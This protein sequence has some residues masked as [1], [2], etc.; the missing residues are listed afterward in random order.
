[1]VN[2]K[3]LFEYLQTELN[4]TEQDLESSRQKWQAAQRKILQD[5][6]GLW[7][8]LDP[9]QTQLEFRQFPEQDLLATL[10]LW[11]EAHQETAGVRWLTWLDARNGRHQEDFKLSPGCRPGLVQAANFSFLHAPELESAPHLFQT[12]SWFDLQHQD[13]RQRQV[14]LLLVPEHQLVLVGVR[15][16]GEVLAV[17]LQDFQVLERWSLREAGS[18]LALNMAVDAEAETLYMTDNHSA[19]LWIVELEDFSHKVFQSGLGALGNLA[20]APVRGKLYLC[21]LRPQ[22]SLV[23]FDTETMQA[24]YSV[25]IKGAS[26]T[27]KKRL[28]QDPFALLEGGKRLA[29]LAW[30][31]REGHEQPAVNVIDGAEVAILRRYALKVE[32]RPVQL[33][34]PA[35]NPFLKAQQLDYLT[36]L[37]EQGL[38]Q[39]SALEQWQVQREEA[40]AQAL[41]KPQKRQLKPVKHNFRIFQPPKPDPELWDRIGEKGEEIELPNAALEAIVDLI[42]WAFYRM[43]LTNLRIHT[44]EIKRIYGIARKIKEEL[45]TQQ[46]VLAKLDHVLGRHQFQTPIDRKDV[47]EVMRRAK[48]SGESFRLE[49]LCPICSGPM[50]ETGCPNCGFM[51]QLPPDQRLPLESYSA[52][53]AT[54][55]FPGQML[56]AHAP[57]KRL[58]TLN[59]WRQP[60]QE[61]D[62]NPAGL[63]SVQAAVALPNQNFLVADAVGNKVLEVSPSGDVLWW[64]KLALKRPVQATWYQGEKELHYLIVDQGNARILEM[65]P[66]GKHL[67]R[68]PT[69]KTPDEDKLK[70]PVD[71][72]FTETDT[73]LI[74][75]L[76]LP[77]VLEVDRRGS[78]VRGFGPEQGVTRPLAARRN[79]DGSTEILDAGS[80]TWLHFD[81]E[82]QEIERF[83]YWPPETPDGE[84]WRAKVAPIWGG[85]LHNGE[86]I[87]LGD[88]YFMF[89]APALGLIRWVAALPDP[90][91]EN[92]LLKVRF[93]TRSNGDLRLQKLKEF[94][95]ALKKVP[96]LNE[97]EEEKIQELARY[98]HAVKIRAGDWLNAPGETPNGICFLLEGELELRAPEAEQPLMQTLGSGEICGSEAAGSLEVLQDYQPGLKAKTEVRLLMLDRGD[99]KRA[100]VVFPRLFT[101]VKQLN[102]DYGRLVKHFK[103]RKMELF[104]GNLRHS[105]AESKIREQALFQTASDDFME[106]LAALVHPHAYLPDQEVFGRG[107]SGGSMFLILEGKVG[108]MRK[109]EQRPSVM[110]A[111]GDLFGEMSLIFDMPRSVTART[112]DYC[113]FF[114]MEYEALKKIWVR[115][116]WFHTR[117]QEMARQRQEENQAYDLEYARRSGTDRSDLPTVQVMPQGLRESGLIFYYASLRHDCVLGINLPGE[118]LWYWGQEPQRQLFQPSRS[119]YLGDSLLVTDSGNDRVLEI[120]LRSREILRHWRGQLN[121]PRSGSLTPE[122]FLLVADQGNQR[123]VVINEEGR[124]LWTHAAPKEILSPTFA[125]ITPN[126]TILFAD[127]GLHQV[128]EI[129]RTGE[130]LWS[131]GEM[132]QAGSADAQLSAPQCVRRLEDGSTLIADTGNRRL[133]WLH[134]EAKNKVIDLSHLDPPLE[135]QHCDLLETGEILVFS[136]EQ[137]RFVRLTR[138]GEVNWQADLSFPA[139]TEGMETHL[140]QTQFIPPEE[141]WIL[142]LERLDELDERMPEAPAETAPP[143]ADLDAALDAALEETEEEEATVTRIMNWH[144][145]SQ[146][147][148][149]RPE[150]PQAAAAAAPEQLSEL[151][152][153]LTSMEEKTIG[154]DHKPV[155]WSADKKSEPESESEEAEDLSVDGEEL[156]ALFAELEVTGTRK[157]VEADLRSSEAEQASEEPES[158][159]DQ[160]FLSELDAALDFMDGPSQ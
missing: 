65:E 109:G 44:D 100:V 95:A 20:C 110:L 66:G 46:V 47:F 124:E 156:D 14:D 22:L 37:Q 104:Q 88:D 75:D 71:V 105:L 34:E 155:Q 12:R 85:R 42:N 90:A 9:D 123:L 61:V 78:V 32:N 38:V 149:Q 152:D 86:W 98:V 28:P 112:L 31:V 63:K 72:Q 126:N 15:E 13:K 121:L 24:E 52:E 69:M 58:L 79:R 54:A 154:K 122:G 132:K 16:A 76:G 23:Y 25:D 106:T 21:L 82:G 114:E 133:V 137:D 142:D 160:A 148:I 119:L 96:A 118:V 45:K 50:E 115:F 117:L 145:L 17:S 4:W 131:H 116:P 159:A 97:E 84:H 107:E 1:M 19:Q 6:E 103:E 134:P 83:I 77:R 153:L 5:L 43:T 120:D 92:D 2:D 53:A 127:A 67:R 10:P 11:E 60:L 26:W 157:E 36:W 27:E 158:E 39:L 146:K 111:E 93:K 91:K 147:G 89:M 144:E 143:V 94:T 51:L 68:Y 101:L 150:L 70:E 7:I 81:A 73:W 41:D 56:L 130:V 128:Y 40:K 55:L 35:A 59:I 129:S 135:I 74:S 141:R 102:F 33:G 138:H 113:K 125:E 62:L 49:D 29:L 136:S 8:G 140:K 80:S 57:L 151:D 139:K 48:L 3:E 108:L 30:V 87:L 18:N 64:A 99:Y